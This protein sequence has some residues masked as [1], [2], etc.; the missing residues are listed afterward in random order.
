M[1]TFVKKQIPV[2]F[3]SK[4]DSTQFGKVGGWVGFGY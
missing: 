1:S 4:T 2:T 3:K